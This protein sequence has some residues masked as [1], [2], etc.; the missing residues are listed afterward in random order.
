MLSRCPCCYTCWYRPR[1]RRCTSRSMHIYCFSRCFCHSRCG[2]HVRCFTRRCCH[3]CHTL[4]TLPLS[5]AHELY[6]LCLHLKVSLLSSPVS[7]LIARL[8]ADC[9]YCLYPTLWIRC[10]YLSPVVTLQTC[11]FEVPLVAARHRLSWLAC[12]A[13]VRNPRGQELAGETVR[14]HCCNNAKPFEPSARQEGFEVQDARFSLECLL[15]DALAP[16]AAHVDT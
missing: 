6:K 15:R 10:R 16:H 13:G 9:R 7:S 5:L 14:G 3:S 2:C 12:R 8:Q 11:R 1:C 4:A